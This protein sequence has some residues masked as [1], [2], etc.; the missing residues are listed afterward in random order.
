MSAR[1][2]DAKRY[3]RERLMW[4]LVG[5]A[6]F[7]AYAGAW[8]FISPHFLVDWTDNRW[9]GLLVFAAAFGLGFEVLTL[10]LGYYTDY[11]LEHRYDMSN[12]TLS[13]FMIQQLKGWAVGGVIGAVIL[14]GLY[15]LLWYAGTSW[16]LWTWVGW[17]SLTVLLAQLFPK[18]L[19]P[20]FYKTA[21]LDDPALHERL[22]QLASGTSLR[23]DG[24]YNLAL[25]A[26]TKAANAMLTGLGNT[27][28]VYLSDTLLETFT[29]QEIEVVFAHE[30]GHHT[31]GHIWKSLALGAALGSVMIGV[32]VWI[33]HPLSGPDAGQW[34][35]AVLALPT[36]AL[37]LGLTDLV[38]K[39]IYNAVSRR[40]ERQ[41]DS[42]A[43]KRTGN[44]TAYR[45]AFERLAELNLADPD[46]HPFIEWYF[47]DHP[48]MTKRIALADHTS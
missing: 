9:L 18:L 19:L 6:V 31:R 24:V 1:Q 33:L 43:L 16:W 41:C 2:D 29:P 48:A 39:P 8:A 23:V 42:D 7:L 37:C 12:Q 10:P 35:A 22:V 38:T 28:R 4:S 5:T 13:R 47:H 20:V 34:P 3:A 21:P 15:A 40:F 27:R 26:D 36:I 14:C 32:L 17:I 25:S 45:S 44:P 30:L 46:P 11:L